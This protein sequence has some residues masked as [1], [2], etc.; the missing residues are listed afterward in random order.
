MIWAVFG[1][2]SNL[3]DCMVSVPYHLSKWHQ[4]EIICLAY[5]QN[6]LISD[7]PVLINN[8]KENRKKIVSR[9]FSFYEMR[10]LV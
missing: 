8:F 9:R 4:K 1:P 3:L 6:N 7:M 10:Q 5:P 2:H